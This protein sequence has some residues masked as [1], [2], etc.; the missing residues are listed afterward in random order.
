MLFFLI[1]FTSCAHFSMSVFPWFTFL[2]TPSPA[3]PFY[4]SHTVPSNIL[5]FCL[6]VIT[7]PCLGAFFFFVIPSFSLTFTSLL[8]GNLFCSPSFFP[9][10][11]RQKAKHVFSY[12]TFKSYTFANIFCFFVT[13]PLTLLFPHSFLG[14]LFIWSLL[15]FI[16]PVLITAWHKIAAIIS[17]DFLTYVGSILH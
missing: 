10:S 9:Y 4:Y 6:M 11:F 12:P 7:S 5:F 17:Y 2:A 14:L 15:L 13:F 8:P 3:C 1:H 16:L